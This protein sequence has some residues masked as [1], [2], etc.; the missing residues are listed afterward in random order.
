[1][2][3]KS[4]KGPIKKE[5]YESETINTKTNLRG[6]FGQNPT[7]RKEVNALKAKTIQ[8]AKIRGKLGTKMKPHVILDPEQK[9]GILIRRLQIGTYIVITIFGNIF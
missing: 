4:G 7:G 3:M 6:G 2:S 5:V 1:M 8:E 9:L